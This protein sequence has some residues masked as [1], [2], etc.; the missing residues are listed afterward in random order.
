LPGLDPGPSAGVPAAAAVAEPPPLDLTRIEEAVERA[1]AAL[2]AIGDPVDLNGRDQDS[3]DQDDAVEGEGGQGAPSRD[4]RLVAWYRR[5]A[6]V[7]E[8]LVRLETEA[9]DSSRPL[10]ETPASVAG[11]LERIGGDEVAVADLERLGRMWL[12]KR[13][14][15]ASGAAIVATLEESR[16]VGPYW[17]THTSVVEVDAN[18]PG[19]KVTI[20]SRRPPPAEVGD[21][22]IAAGVMFDDDTVWAAEVWPVGGV[23]TADAVEGEME[24]ELAGEMADETGESPEDASGIR[25]DDEPV[26]RG[27]RARRAPFADLDEP[28]AG[29]PAADA[30]APDGAEPADDEAPGEEPEMKDGDEGGAEPSEPETTEPETDAS[31]SKPDSTESEPVEPAAEKPAGAKPD[32]DAAEDDAADAADPAPAPP[33][34][35]EAAAADEAVDSEAA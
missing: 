32:A 5:L 21:R 11:L 17:I 30:P 2:D 18:E 31:E 1:C 34:A 29:A 24:D 33:A 25:L 23:A 7:G 4:R 3:G 15:R 8:E 28:D 9:A 13:A 22:V 19:R 35:G 26:V 20:V 16:R 10:D 27:R 6:R 12:T 14:Q